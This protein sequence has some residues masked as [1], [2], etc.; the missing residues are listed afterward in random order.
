MIGQPGA[1][2]SGG[3]SRLCLQIHQLA[4]RHVVEEAPGFLREFPVHPLCPCGHFTAGTDRG[5]VSGGKFRFFLPDG[6][7][8]GM[9]ALF[10][11]GVQFLTERD[12]IFQDLLPVGF[13]I[14]PVIVEAVHP[15]IPEIDEGFEAQTVCH[16]CADL[17]QVTEE[18]LQLRFVLRKPS[19][20]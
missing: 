13:H 15:Q 3:F 6:K 12:D 20:V 5:R 1:V 18:C 9:Q 10:L 2:A 7:G 16:V 19:P 4:G 14:L 17:D 8:R 11:R